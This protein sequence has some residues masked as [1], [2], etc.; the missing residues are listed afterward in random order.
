MVANS[1]SALRYVGGV[2]ISTSQ[3][4]LVVFSL[5]ATPPEYTDF[6]GRKDGV[7][8]NALFISMDKV[9]CGKSL[10]KA[11]E[12]SALKL[13][14]QN[15]AAEQIFI[16]LDDDMGGTEQDRAFFTLAARHY[17]NDVIIPYPNNGQR[18]EPIELT[19][20]PLRREAPTSTSEENN[21]IDILGILG[22]LIM[23]NQ[24]IIGF[25]VGVALA[26]AGCWLFRQHPQSTP[27][28]GSHIEFQLEKLPKGTQGYQLPLALNIIEEKNGKRIVI[29]LSE[30]KEAVH[31]STGIEQERG[32]GK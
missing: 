9:P 31:E 28:T 21:T 30:T 16:Q 26:V 3:Q 13:A 18:S 17:E 2:F 22:E 11:W 25:I 8:L 4:M 23:K 15:T 10:K 20:E 27:V 12:H 24:F 19:S 14:P 32:K 6:R 29:S 7:V 1:G 5:R